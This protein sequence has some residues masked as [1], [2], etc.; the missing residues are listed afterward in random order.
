MTDLKP[1]PF[2]GSTGIYQDVRQ[3]DLVKNET[4]YNNFVVCTFCCAQTQRYTTREE[5]VNNW[6]TRPDTKL[7]EVI[8][9]VEGMF[10]LDN[11][12]DDHD[13]VRNQTIS[14]VL[15]KIKAIREGK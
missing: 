2:C 8:E 7:G 13:I 3:W 10:W 5:A 4:T 1:C 6:N 9:A 14:E 11:G 12:K 15:T